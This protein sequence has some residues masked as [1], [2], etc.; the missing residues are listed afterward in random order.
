LPADYQWKYSAGSA[1]YIAHVNWADDAIDM[2]KNGGLITYAYEGLAFVVARE[3]KNCRAFL[4]LILTAKNVF[5]TLIG[6]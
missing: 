5:C 4:C 3:R 2:A 6:R 1:S